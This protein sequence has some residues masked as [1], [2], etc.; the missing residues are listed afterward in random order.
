MGSEPMGTVLVEQRNDDGGSCID[1]LTRLQLYSV[2]EY[3]TM[4]S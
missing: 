3:F 4:L 2:P 1:Y